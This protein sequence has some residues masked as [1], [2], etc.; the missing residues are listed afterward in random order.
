MSRT[1]PGLP[2]IVEGDNL[3]DLI[4]RALEVASREHPD[5]GLEAGEPRLAQIG[6]VRLAPIWAT[7]FSSAS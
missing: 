2:E 3:A 7:H 4:V 6:R 5:D 1:L